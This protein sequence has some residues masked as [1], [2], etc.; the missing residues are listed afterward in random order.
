MFRN[1][2]YIVEED[3]GW[4]IGTIISDA[5]VQIIS[6]AEDINVRSGYTHSMI[7]MEHPVSLLLNLKSLSAS[8]SLIIPVVSGVIRV[9][10]EYMLVF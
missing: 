6:F 8:S 7:H 4:K 5:S 1:I 2:Y 9:F 3:D 10:N